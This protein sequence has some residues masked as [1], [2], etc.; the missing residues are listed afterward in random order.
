MDLDQNVVK[1]ILDDDPF[2]QPAASKDHRS[3][4]TGHRIAEPDDLEQ[5]RLGEA[6]HLFIEGADD[7]DI[8]VLKLDE[9]LDLA[10]TADPDDHAGGG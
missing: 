6:L 9:A 8:V 10:V 3:L 1:S 4:L 7:D 5:T 2:A